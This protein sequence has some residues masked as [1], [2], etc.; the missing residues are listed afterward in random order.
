M[1]INAE[2]T[3]TTNL[4]GLYSLFQYMDKQN[5]FFRNYLL[6]HMYW[7]LYYLFFMIVTIYSCDLLTKEVH[8]L[9]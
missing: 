7:V 5:E 9:A 8:D 1:I 2:L 4:F 6:I 3:F